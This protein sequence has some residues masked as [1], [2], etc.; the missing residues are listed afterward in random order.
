MAF[1]SDILLLVIEVNFVQKRFLLSV[2]LLY[3]ALSFMINLLI[4]V[5]MILILRITTEDILLFI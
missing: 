2:K 1:M 3:P 4:K 5:C